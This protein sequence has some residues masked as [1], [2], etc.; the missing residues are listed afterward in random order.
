M[1][2][3][4]IPLPTRSSA[5]VHVAPANAAFDAAYATLSLIGPRVC[6]E[7]IQITLPPVRP[8]CWAAK[9]FVSNSVARVFTAQCRS[10]AAGVRSASPTASPPW[11]WLQTSTSTWPSVP[12]TAGI[13]PSAAA[14]S[15]RSPATSTTLA[16]SPSEA[17]SSARMSARFSEAP[18]SS[19]SCRRWWWNA[20]DAPID[21][22]RDAT[23]KPIPR[24]RLTPVTTAVRPAR[25][26]DMDASVS[27]HS[28]TSAHR[29]D[30][31]ADPPGVRLAPKAYPSW[32]T[33]TQGAE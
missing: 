32:V 7:V 12:F 4:T 29:H 8:S 14:T 33:V 27:A 10:N 13:S 15:P 11:A 31:S 2:L 1:V 30:G 22:S 23:A 6:P 19:E 17:R 26:N 18:Y 25:G 9:A 24:L 20:R 3:R 5:T 21:T 16:P 28:D